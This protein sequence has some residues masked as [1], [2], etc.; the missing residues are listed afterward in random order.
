[1]NVKDKRRLQLLLVGFVILFISGISI[2][3]LI[4]DHYRSQ[5]VHEQTYYNVTCVSPQGQVYYETYDNLTHL[6]NSIMV[7]GRVNS[8]LKKPDT[9]NDLL[10]Q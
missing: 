3:I 10:F 6:E 7:C 9:Q 2:F 5:G 8:A 1:M 4:V